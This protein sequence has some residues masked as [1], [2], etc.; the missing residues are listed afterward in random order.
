MNDA[1]AS[2]LFLRIKIAEYLGD[3][4]K[5]KQLSFRLAELVNRRH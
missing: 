4:E 1:A 3:R 5:V 2:L